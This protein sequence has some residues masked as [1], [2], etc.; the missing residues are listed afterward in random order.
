[1][2][3]ITPC[4]I[5]DYQTMFSLSQLARE[6]ANGTPVSVNTGAGAICAL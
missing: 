6:L 1:M 4:P 5:S 3:A 2:R